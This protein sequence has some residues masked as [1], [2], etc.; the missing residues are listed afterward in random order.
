MRKT[1]V[2]GG[3]TRS[4]AVWLTLACDFIPKN[5][6]NGTSTDSDIVSVV[7]MGTVSTVLIDRQPHDFTIFAGSAYSCIL[8]ADACCKMST[9]HLLSACFRARLTGRKISGSDGPSEWGVTS[10]DAGA[11]AAVGDA[12]ATGR[13]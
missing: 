3:S 12:H 10:P 13:A 1:D 6:E 7:S 8:L 4:D 11:P 9:G 5:I 2:T